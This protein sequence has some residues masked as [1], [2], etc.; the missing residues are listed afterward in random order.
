MLKGVAQRAIGGVGQAGERGRLAVGIESGT[1]HRRQR[2]RL[3]GRG[4][5]VE[6]IGLREIR[7]DYV[8]GVYQREQG[9]G[10][11]EFGSVLSPIH[12]AIAET[13]GRRER[14]GGSRQV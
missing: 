6:A 14:V 10:G 13:G 4:D 7:R 1:V 8:V 3:G 9:G 2:G 11:A 5:E 12:K